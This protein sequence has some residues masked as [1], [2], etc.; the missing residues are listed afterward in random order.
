MGTSSS[1]KGSPSNVPMVPPWVPD[2]PSDPGPDGSPSDLPSEATP[3]TPQSVDVDIEAG[4]DQNVP[5]SPLTPIDER[6]RLAPSG[7]FGSARTN[8]A[9][10]ARN[11]DRAAMRRGIGQYVSQ[12]YRGSGTATRRMGGT[13]QS[14]EALFSALSTGADNAFR[15]PGAQ[16]DPAVLAGQSADEVM[17]AVTDA[18]RPVDGT[19]DAESSR[20]ALQDALADTLD[21]FPDADL[22]NLTNEQKEYAVEVFVSSDIYGRLVLDL[23]TKVID[24]APSFSAGLGRLREIRDYIRE[25][26]AASFRGLREKGVY[27]S[28]GR[29]SSVVR[30]AIR[31]TFV[32]FEGYAL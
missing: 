19:Q 14:S 20:A 24:S 30:E 27:L 13:I 32:V 7:R 5:A 15:A 2:I 4:E 6:A 8:L 9:S 29:V 18:V 3:S 25:T 10:F 22:L 31:E 28:K 23:G 21:R 12:G 1:S 11:S 26:V 16:L 17:D